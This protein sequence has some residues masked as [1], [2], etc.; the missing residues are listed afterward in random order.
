MNDLCI[1]TK[2]VNLDA[3]NGVNMIALHKYKTNGSLL[4]WSVM[5]THT[6]D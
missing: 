5:T 6:D 4:L 1:V 2:N 3:R